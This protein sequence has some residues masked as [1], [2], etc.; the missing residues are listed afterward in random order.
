M[1]HVEHFLAFSTTCRENG[2]FLSQQQIEL[3]R[4][5]VALLLEWNAKLNLISRKDEQNIWGS[6]ILHSVSLLFGRTMPG[7]IR[8]LDIGTGGGLPG[9]PLGILNPGWSLTLM[10]SIGKK[11]TATSDMVGRLGIGNIDVVQGRAEEPSALASRR[12]KYDLVV[13]RGVASLVQLAGWSRPYLKRGHVADRDMEGE[14]LPLPSLAAYKG[15]DLE[16]ELRELRIKV[17]GAVAGVS[18]LVFRGGAVAGLE[19]K[20]VVVVQFT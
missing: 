13:A 20:K 1:F 15:G 14:R 11:V 7:A 17:P 8:V 10:D 2:L 19:E 18:P 16:S 5:Y 9:I 3:L 12:G 6:H 4:T